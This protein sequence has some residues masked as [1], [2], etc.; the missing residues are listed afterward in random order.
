MPNL[1]SADALILALD[2][3]SSST[4]AKFFDTHGGTVD[5]VLVQ[6][7][8]KPTTT[9]DGGSMLDPAELS[10]TLFETIDAI[11]QQAKDKTAHI[12]AVAMDTLVN[13]IMGIDAHGQPTTPIYTWADT[14]GRDLDDQLK[15]KLTPAAYT[16]RTG[17]RIH[18]SYSPLRLLWL[19][20][21]ESDAFR[22]TAYWLSF[23][24][25]VL[26]QLFGQRQVSLSVASWSGLLNRFSNDWDAETLAVLPIHR[27]QLSEISAQPLQGLSKSFATRWPTLKNADWLPAIGDGVASNIGAGCTTPERVALSVGTSGALRIIVSGRPA[28]VPDGLFA[29]CLDAERS[30]IGGPLSNAGNLYAWLQRVLAIKA[31]VATSTD[32]LLPDS[33]GLTILPFLA[34]ERAPGWNDKAQAVFMGMTLD[35]APEHLVQAALEAVAYR[36]YQIARRLAPLLPEKVVYMAN[37]AAI[38]HSPLWLQIMAD[39]LG[40]P[41]YTNM[42]A[43]ATI[44]GAAVFAAD[45]RELPTLQQ[46]YLPDAGRRAIY[47]AAAERQQALYDKLF[48]N[49]H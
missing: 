29:Y 3:G 33:H 32:A 12:A 40:A 49:P 36:F 24:E 21:H 42:D 25:Y 22:R 41:V 11:L 17:C 13:N 30:L 28:E 18:T 19:Q 44:R 14:R 1:L 43:E 48:A 47:L 16:R 9:P 2:I 27:D 5:D 4:R 26:Y 8:Y 6:V 35:T 39:V 31:E 34:G 10:K 7:H 38:T 15:V 37:G 20:A 46:P 23:G 45:Y